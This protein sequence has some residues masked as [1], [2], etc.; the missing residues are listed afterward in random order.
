VVVGRSTAVEKIGKKQGKKNE[1]EG[2]G[3]VGLLKIYKSP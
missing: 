3:R 2:S 1:G